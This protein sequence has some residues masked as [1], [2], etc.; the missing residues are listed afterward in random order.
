MKRCRVIY[1]LFDD[2]EE[3]HYVSSS[4][5][6]QE[7]EGLVEKYK[8]RKEKVYAKDFIKYL[9]KYDPK[10]EEVTVKDFYF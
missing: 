5:D 9:T 3:K 10:A 2:H 7:L 8:K 4:L 6:H 1:R